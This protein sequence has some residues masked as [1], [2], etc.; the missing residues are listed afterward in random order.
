MIEVVAKS[1]E[2][3]IVEDVFLIPFYVALHL[4]SQVVQNLKG[5]LLLIILN[6][7]E[8]SVDFYEIDQVL[9]WAELP[10]L[11]EDADH[12]KQFL[13]SGSG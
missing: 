8:E 12:V 1:L 13:V 3:F 11:L 6:N 5:Y 4:A 9:D 2:E 10:F 7:F